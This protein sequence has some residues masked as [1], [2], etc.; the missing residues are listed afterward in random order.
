VV[1][2]G[3]SIPVI[4]CIMETKTPWHLLD[5]ITNMYNVAWPTSK[6]ILLKGSFHVSTFSMFLKSITNYKYNTRKKRTY[7]HNSCPSS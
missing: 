3:S 5:Y 2:D 1:D 7:E 4:H 6:L